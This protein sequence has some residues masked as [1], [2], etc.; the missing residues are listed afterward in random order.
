M[1]TALQRFVQGSS[2]LLMLL[3][4]TTAVEANASGAFSPDRLRRL[5]QSLH[6]Y[7]DDSREAGV[8]MQPDTLF[9]IASQSKAITSAMVLSLM[10]EGRIQLA[11]PVSKTIPAFAE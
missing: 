9:R 4:L 7:V 3:S 11:D 1:I 8:R 2:T 6:Q 5:D 10:E